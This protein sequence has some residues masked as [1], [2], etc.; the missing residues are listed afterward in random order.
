MN[1]N[2]IATINRI[3]KTIEKI[4]ALRDG[5]LSEL[6]EIAR[7]AETDCSGKCAAYLKVAKEEF[8]E[9]YFEEAM[10]ALEKALKC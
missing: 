8:S 3:I 9:F 2:Y 7:R 10:A 6:M 5:A 4:D 1:E